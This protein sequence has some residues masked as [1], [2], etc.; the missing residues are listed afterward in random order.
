LWLGPRLAVLH[1]AAA[2]PF[3]WKRFDG[4]RWWAYSAHGL[5]E[6]REIFGV[7]DGIR[8]LYD[9][10][11]LRVHQPL[12]DPDLVELLLSFPPELAFDPRYDRPLLRAA[13]GGLIPEQI[14]TSM[15]KSD[16]TAMLLS[17]IVESDLPFASELLNAPQAQVRAFV[18]PQAVAALLHGS[19][20]RH[21]GG[22]RRWA[23]DVWRLLAAECWLRQQEDP[24]ELHRLL[25]RAGQTRTSFH[26]ESPTAP[27]TM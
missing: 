16:F 21:P 8:R 14:R 10:G 27:A 13:A 15:N 2:D 18:R 3:A 22:P 12:L 4:P 1:S 25:E 23:V 11:G 20:D 17:G 7:S 6:R 5:T 19:P 26:L 9:G 24:R